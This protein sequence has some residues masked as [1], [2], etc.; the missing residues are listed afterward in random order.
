MNR[1]WI[2]FAAVSKIIPTI[3]SI[4]H[5]EVAY[6][7]KGF[8]CGEFIYT[9]ITWSVYDNYQWQSYDYKESLW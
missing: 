8:M 4:Y 2:A 3:N 9:S 7:W 1:P 5:T 6:R